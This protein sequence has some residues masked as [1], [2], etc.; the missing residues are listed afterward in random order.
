M[1]S[2]VAVSM[3]TV[4]LESLLYGFLLILFSTNLYLRITRYA[5]PQEFSSRGG[6]WW[7]PIVISNI[8]IFATCTAHWI[9]TVDCFFLAFLGSAGDPLQFYLDESRPTSVAR[10]TLVIVV[11]LIGDAVMIH[12]LWL[13]WNRNLR[14]MFVPV[15]SWL[16]AL[17][18]GITVAYSFTQSSQTY[19]MLTA[20]WALTTLINIYCTTFIA[21]RIWKTSRMT[22]E[23]G[24]GLLMPVFVILIES[25]AIW[26]TASIFFGATFLMGSPLAFI[27]RDLIPMIVGVVNQLIYLRVGLGWSPAEAPDATGA[28][29]TSSA[30]IFAV[31]LPTENDEFCP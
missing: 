2:L 26:T 23:V 14:V 28:P 18:D 15:L 12:R 25:A 29:M 17:T 30:S 19:I 4:V 6:I 3:A 5:R 11:G 24:G 9:L 10:N 1:I 8:A 27:G 16:G 20:S 7:N 13:I 22:A 31:G 21:W